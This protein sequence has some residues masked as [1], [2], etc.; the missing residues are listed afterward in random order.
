MKKFALLLAGRLLLSGVAAHA[1]HFIIKGGYNYSNVSLDKSVTV[2]DIKAG[3]SGWQ[4]G[5]AYQTAVAS[6][7]SFQPEL[8]YK[9]KG[10][11]LDD[12]KNMNL[13]YLELPLNVQWGPDLWVA[14]PY[15][16]AGPYV[17]V[18]VSNQFRGNGWTETDMETVKD[19][20]K[21]TEWGIGLGLGIDIWKFQVSG[22][23]NW[24]FGAI[25]DINST[26]AAIGKFQN[27]SGTPRTFEISV[28]LKF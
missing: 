16:F 18:K 24:N 23:Y 7:F 8:I 9:V 5:A 3:R 28:G 25:S 26:D 21:K 17:G 19:G 6:G 27:L 12:V 10:L 4:F 11:R 14:R 13:G 20:L 15:I 22:K 2:A 1:Q